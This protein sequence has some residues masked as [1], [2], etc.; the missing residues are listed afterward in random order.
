MRNEKLYKMN[1]RIIALFLL[2]Y[3]LLIPFMAIFNPSLLTAVCGLAIVI[4]CI[5]N[6][7]KSPIKIQVFALFIT[8]WILLVLKA[9]QPG[10]DVFVVI[11][12]LIIVGPIVIIFLFPFDKLEF[13]EYSIK[14]SKIGFW[15]ICWNP[16]VSGFSYMRFGYGMLP[17]VIL[18]YIDLLYIGNVASSKQRIQSII[19]FSIG[20]LEILLYGARG[21]MFALLLFIFIERFFINKKKIILNAMIIIVGAMIYENLLAILNIFERITQQLGVYSYSITKFKMQ[22]SQGFVEASSGRDVLYRNA[23]ENI[24]KHPW[25]GNS[26]QIDEEGGDYTHNLFLQIGQDLGLIFLI[27]LILFLLFIL[28]K[29][30]SNGLDIHEKLCIA[31]LFSIAIGRLMFSST[32]WRRPEFWMLIYFVVII[33]KKN[34][35]KPVNPMIRNRSPE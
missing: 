24:K 3:T 35:G 27:V 33:C 16:F 13:L 8:M 26:I 19:I 20:T 22:I 6:N 9:L 29:L 15:L 30:W 1:G 25:I 18:I 5:I 17:I 28:M 11:N 23:I 10:T 7:M 12:Y 4:I 21:A 34:R 31:L 32:I 14:L 2:Q